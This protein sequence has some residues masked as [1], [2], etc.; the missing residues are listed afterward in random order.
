MPGFVSRLVL[1]A[2][3]KASLFSRASRAGPRRLVVI[4]CIGLGMLALLIGVSMISYRPPPQSVAAKMPP[5]NPLPGGTHSDPEQNALLLRDAQEH[6]AQALKRRQSYTPPMPASQLMAPRPVVQPADPTPTAPV[7]R[8]APV[9]VTAPRPVPVPAAYT[10]PA[11][12][13]AQQVAVPDPQ[14]GRDY[15]QAAQLF[16][17]WNTPAPRTNVVL[18]PDTGTDSQGSGRRPGVTAE[19]RNIT[20][21]AGPPVTHASTAS[22]PDGQNTGQ[23]LVPAGRGVYAHTVLAVNSDTGGPIVLQ[24]DSGPLAG[25][26]M[27]GNFSKSGSDR[28]VVRV[29]TIEH[30]GHILDVDGIV[31]A[32]DTMETA[33]ASSV[34]E[35]YLER[36]VLPAA[37][38]FIQGL[39]Q[40]IAT[41]TNTQTVLSPFGGASY[42]THLNL[43]QQAGVGAGVAAAQIGSALNQEAPKGPTVNLDANVTVGVM[44]LGNV[45]T[46]G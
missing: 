39:G 38:A 25:D 32:P 30:Q 10:P 7:Q 19:A 29:S 24:A 37:A 27:I 6:A 5:V 3:L 31:V 43:A 44:F 42:A 14:P 23:V 20:R 22:G 15:R 17:A 11:V 40:A 34:D 35:H 2:A 1:P 33:V 8:H 4:T 28:L 36:F 9:V 16:Q 21:N 45:T 18:P 46:K 12:V 13:H 41:T 26:R